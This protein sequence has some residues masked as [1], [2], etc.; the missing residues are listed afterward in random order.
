MS[1]VY[2]PRRLTGPDC[3][4]GMR[5]PHPPARELRDLPE[6]LRARVIAARDGYPSDREFPDDAA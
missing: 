1:V 6:D 4:N 2:F 3:A 5:E